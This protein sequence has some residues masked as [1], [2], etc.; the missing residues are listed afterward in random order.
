VPSFFL[1]RV[2]VAIRESLGERKR[3]GVI[4]A[5]NKKALLTFFFLLLVLV[6]SLWCDDAVFGCCEW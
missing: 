4:R 3:N 2:A 1:S 5:K 6:A